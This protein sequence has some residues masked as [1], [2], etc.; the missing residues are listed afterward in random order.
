MATCSGS[1]ES[2]MKTSSYRFV[3]RINAMLAL[4]LIAAWLCCPVLAAAEPPQNLALTAQAL[5]SESM[6]DLT[7]DKAIDGKPETRW[8]GI[9]GHNEGVWYQLEWKQPVTVGEVVVDQFDTFSMEWDLQVREDASSSWRT[10]RH[11]GKPGQRLP[12]VVTHNMAPIKIVGLRIANITNGPSFNEVQVFERPFADGAAAV[13]ASDLRG[14][15]LGIVCDPLGGAP[16]EGAGVTLSGKTK[17]GPWQTSAKSDA[18]GI[19]SADMPPGLTGQVKVQTTLKTPEMQTAVTVESQVDAIRLP[20]RL[21]PREARHNAVSLNGKWKFSLDPPEGFWQRDF[22]DAAWKE[23]K[24]PANWEMEGFHSDSSVGG[25]RRHFVAPKVP[26]RVKLAFDGVYSGAEVWVNGQLVATHEGITPFEA[27]ITDAVVKGENLLAVR[28]K[29]HTVVSDN[30]DHMSLYADFPLAGIMRP[31]CLFTTPEAHLTGLEITPVFDRDYR[32]ATLKVRAC[33]LNE[34][35][36]PFQGRVTLGLA[37]PLPRNGEVATPQSK[38]VEV[39]PW[40]AKE[41]EVDIPVTTPVKWDAEHPNLYVLST[42]LVTDDETREEFTMRVGFRQTDIRGTEILINGTPVKFHG[43]CH[44]DSHPL[45][46]RAVTPELTRQDLKLMREANLNAVRTSHYLPLADLPYIADE[47]GLYVEAEGSFCWADGTN[48]LRNTPRIMQLNAELLAR[49]RN[50]PSVAFWSVCNES[51]YGYGFQRAHEWMRQADP[52]RPNSA[53]T[54]ATLEIATLHNPI[55]IPRMKQVAGLDRPM[56]FDES[57]GIFQGIFN[58]V[59]ELWVDPGMR[60]Y[61]VEPYV[62]GGIQQFFVKDKVTQGTYIWCWGDDLFC[63]PGRGFEYGR[64]GTRCHYVE[65]SYCIR[66]RGIVGDAPWGVIDGWRRRKPEHWITKKINSP[67]KIKETPLPLPAA[68]EPINVAVEN[69]YDFTNLS[70]LMIHWVIGEQNGDVHADVPARSAGTLAIQ[71]GQAVKEGEILTLQF[72]DGSG[73][74][75]DAYRIALGRELPPPLPGRKC[76]PAGLRIL[77]DG[78]LAGS[79]TTIAGKDFQVAICSDSGLLMRC[80]GGGEPLMMEL[81][82]LHV[83]PTARPQRGLPDRLTWHLDKFDVAKDGENV[84]VTIGG[85]YQDFQGG[86]ELTI[87]PAGELTIASTFEYTGNEF[88]AREIGLRFSVPRDCDVL[89]WDRSAEWNVYP[90]DH[91]GRPRG[92]ARAFPKTANVVPPTGPWSE[93]ISPM[94]S[95]DFRSTKRH[96]NWAAIHYADGPGVAVESNGKQHVRAMVESD[97][98]S[99]HVSDWYGGTSAGWPEWVTIYGSGQPV[100]KGE[101][102]TSKL[103]LSIRGK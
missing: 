52:S 23:I 80:V 57:H 59:A 43:T 47:L 67:V 78:W 5:A 3:V 74:I 92:T 32:D 48:D 2:L 103:K 102:I 12:K 31:V 15:F 70:E 9:S 88:L 99:V 17:S 10:I 96:V 6:G 82:M 61:Y 85:R 87:T 75:V 64:I 20:Y 91:I 65:N 19:F 83:L 36:K 72:I 93:D 4:L 89:D 7:P 95:N 94:G 55:A 39:E 71:P 34:S 41:I 45:L 56:L 8:S 68:G 101:R 73:Q 53:A 81:P 46:G 24:V 22:D 16:I 28:V 21:T 26:G 1:K 54:S 18:K 11:F 58:D 42:R 30:L 51:Q 44:H 63:V 27:D 76:T 79:V 60:D 25:Y 100:R 77:R 50:H 86:Y 37:G 35:S 84:R 97:R 98:I 49:D 90:P 40:Q 38:A 29:E 13:V 14:H 62:Q 66:G 69:Q 33:V